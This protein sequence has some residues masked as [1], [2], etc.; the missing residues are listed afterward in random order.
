MTN[1]IGDGDPGA[2][3]AARTQ[4]QIDA[5]VDDGDLDPF[6]VESIEWNPSISAH[7]TSGRWSVSM[8]AT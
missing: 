7:V 5:A 1:A 3:L 2:H 8:A 6:A 4:R